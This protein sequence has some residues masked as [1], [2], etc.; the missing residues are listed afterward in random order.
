M[1]DYDFVMNGNKIEEK[2]ENAET[3]IDIEISEKESSHNVFDLELA[4]SKF[5][6]KNI[7]NMVVRAEKV[8]ITNDAEAK[9]GVCLAM[10]AR[11]MCNSIEKTRKEIVRPHLDF[12]KAVKSYSDGFADCLK[13]LEKGLLKK[14]ET[15]QKEGEEFLRIAQEKQIER[16]REARLKQEKEQREYDEAIK[17]REIEIARAEIKAKK[18]DMP[19]PPEPLMPSLP[20][21]LFAQTSVPLV[22]MP[23]KI[24]SEDGNSTTV[25]EW[26]YEI[27]DESLVPRKYLIIDNQLIKA[28]VKKGCRAIAGVKI[29]EKTVRKYRVKG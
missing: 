2:E 15:F 23:K 17:L 18:E 29:I 14:V 27:I 4:K 1:I 3:V 19:L 9:I 21:E 7:S 26:H 8:V 20:S 24:E 6:P 28:D 16:E 5:S 25:S 22:E 10:Q 12:Q 11:K 13:K